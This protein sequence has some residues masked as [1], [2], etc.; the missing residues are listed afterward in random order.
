MNKFKQIVALLLSF[1]AA[2]SLAIPAYA[3]EIQY[4]PEVAEEMTDYGFWA[5]LQKDADKINSYSKEGTNTTKNAKK[6]ISMV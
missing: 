1:T 2:L 3:Q 5:D 6:K 4:L